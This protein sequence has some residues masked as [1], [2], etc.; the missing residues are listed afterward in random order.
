LTGPGFTSSPSFPEGARSERYANEDVLEVFGITTGADSPAG[1]LA[2][3]EMDGAGEEAAFGGVP[4]LTRINAITTVTAAT[5]LP[6]IVPKSVRP[7]CIDPP[8]P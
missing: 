3:A 5:M 7:R 2:L 4:E 1:E 8:T 6:V